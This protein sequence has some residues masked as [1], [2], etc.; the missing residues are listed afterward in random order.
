MKLHKSIELFKNAII[1]TSQQRGIPEIYIEKDYWVTYVLFNIYK[2][3]IGKE[4]VFKGGTALSKCFGVIQRFSEDIDLVIMR[5]ESDSGNRLKTKI[6]KISK[7]ATNVLKERDIEGI[8]NKVGMIRKTVHE[9]P[10]TFNGTFGQ[11]RDMIIVEATWLGNFEPYKETYI[12]SFI[13][14]MLKEQNNQNLIEKYEMNPFKVLVLSSQRTLCEKIMSLVRFS[15]TN[16]PIDDLRNKVRHVYDIHM[17][18]QDED[19]KSFA[20]SDE[21]ESMLLQVANEDILSFKNNNEWLANHP[22][23]AIIFSDPINIW[24]QIKGVYNG[25]FSELVFGDLPTETDI[26]KSIITIRDRLKPIKWNL[27]L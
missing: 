19:L 9:Y 8:T 24:N 6:R 27:V 18:L 15:H 22:I 10:R 4:T 2:N 23:S 11:V 21:F 14:E 13:Y 25:S 26:L 3:E 7:C 20:E 17:M 16:T 5:N 1:A 12:S